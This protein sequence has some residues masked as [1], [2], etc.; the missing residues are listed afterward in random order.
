MLSEAAGGNRRRL[1]GN[2]RS[3]DGATS[4][5]SS[6]TQEEVIEG[7]ETSTEDYSI[8]ISGTEVSEEKDDALKGEQGIIE[9]MERNAEEL[10]KKMH[11]EGE[12]NK[13][14][15]QEQ[16]KQ[17][18]KL[19]NS[20]CTNKENKQNFPPVVTLMLIYIHCNLLLLLLLL[21]IIT[22]VTMQNVNVM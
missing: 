10:E 7:D 4:A 6:A 5:S 14:K 15:Q 8:C 20:V 11:H 16:Q 22:T 19:I 13:G 1:V 2:R 17:E 3:L 12:G 21:I 9:E 18:Q